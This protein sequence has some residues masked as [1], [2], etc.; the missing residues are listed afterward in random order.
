MLARTKAQVQTIRVLEKVFEER[1]QKDITVEALE[2]FM[3]DL[4]LKPDSPTF[5]DDLIWMAAMCVA[6]AEPSV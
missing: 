3:S 6:L 2:G 1:V 5:T 4:G